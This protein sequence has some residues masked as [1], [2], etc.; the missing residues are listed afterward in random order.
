MSILSTLVCFCFM[1]EKNSLSACL[2]ERE[3]KFAIVSNYVNRS[4]LK[5][6]RVLKSTHGKGQLVQT[7]S[8]HMQLFDNEMCSVV[9]HA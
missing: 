9:S 7:R 1:S 6:I 3:S 2:G 5:K 8:I 4:S